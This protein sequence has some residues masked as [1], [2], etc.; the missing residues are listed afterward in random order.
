M[1]K[2]DEDDLLRRCQHDDHTA[3]SC[4]VECFQDR[5]FRLSFRVLGDAA[6]AEDATADTLARVWLRCRS[7]RAESSAGTWIYRIAWRSIL[8]QQR[9]QARWS[10]IWGLKEVLAKSNALEMENSFATLEEKA[11]QSKRL[12]RALG[13]L[14]GEERAVVHM[15]YFEQ[16]SLIEISEIVSTSRNTLKMRLSR[17]RKKLR[18]LLEENEN[19]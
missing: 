14:S 18:G 5:I 12:Q 15:Y 16:K 3:M 7:W 13:A 2:A 8:D 6:L 1:A 17:I 9:G 11:D 4:L 19:E 10:K